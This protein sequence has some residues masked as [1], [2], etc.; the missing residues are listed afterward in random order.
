VLRKFCGCGRHLLV[1]GVVNESEWGP[2]VN[3]RVAARMFAAEP[4]ARMGRSYLNCVRNLLVAG[5]PLS[6]A[7]SKCESLQKGDS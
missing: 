4:A 7:G 3:L 1:S 2:D 5:L 6:R